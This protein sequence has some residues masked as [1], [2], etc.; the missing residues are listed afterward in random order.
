MR[1][2][3]FVL[4]ARKHCDETSQYCGVDKCADGCSPDYH[5]EK[6]AFVVEAP[7]ALKQTEERIIDD[8]H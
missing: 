8:E 3:W 7:L 5:P 6:V 2:P 4:A 1:V